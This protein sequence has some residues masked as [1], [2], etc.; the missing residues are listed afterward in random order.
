MTSVN[1]IN[2]VSTW[3]AGFVIMLFVTSCHFASD[4]EVKNTSESTTVTKD[5]AR[6]VKQ[7]TKTDTASNSKKQSADQRYVNTADLP[8]VEIYNFYI[9]NR[10]T[11]CIAIE[12]ATTKTLN[13]YFA[14][15]VKQGRIKRQVLNVD[16]DANKALSEKYQ[17]FGSSL[18]VTRVFRGRETTTDLTGDGFKYAKN[19]EE[20]FIEIL[21][22]TISG[23]LK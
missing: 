14:A 23:Y 15:E 13:S 6:P 22:N 1:K 12:E 21:K 17:A 9:T 10:C 16:D 11:S 4:K 5:S 18:F 19:K 2:R 3:I 20:K 7:E 8:K